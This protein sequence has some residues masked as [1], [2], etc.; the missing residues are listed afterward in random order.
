MDTTTSAAIDQ[1]VTSWR[2]SV[3][4]GLAITSVAIVLVGLATI[5]HPTKLSYGGNHYADWLVNYAGGF[6][7]R[8]LSGEII[9][10][11][12]GG[13]PAIVVTN[14][15]VFAI[16][17]AFALGLCGL[18]AAST[19]RWS[20]TAL[21]LLAPGSI[22]AMATGNDFYY[23]KEVL[24]H[25]CLVLSALLVVGI[26]KTSEPR[27]KAALLHGLTGFITVVFAVVP[28]MHE[29]FIFLS[30]PAHLLLLYFAG[31]HTGAK[32]GNIIAALAFVSIAI[33]CF[34][35]L[36]KG[37]TGTA[38]II[39]N[40][41]SSVDRHLI[42]PAAPGVPVGGI[43]AIGLSLTRAFQDVFAMLAT[44]YAWFWLPPFVFLSGCGLLISKLAI[45][46]RRGAANS[47]WWYLDLYLLV[48]LC[49][50]P[51]YLL[52]I[53]W[54]RWLSSNFICYVVVLVVCLQ[55]EAAQGHRFS[56]ASS[57]AYCR[58]ML[59]HLMVLWPRYAVATVLLMA[60]TVKMPECCILGYDQTPMTLLI[61][62]IKGGTG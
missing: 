9:Q 21:V 3:A 51:I 18:L 54:G 38:A 19:K 50:A 41:L 15:I 57:P 11:I 26:A 6:V 20:I 47:I 60:V 34:T 53:D 7:R 43:G 24:F 12:A 52:A 39:W 17:A 16:F 10:Q 40:S 55:L 29:G 42:N 36:F 23:R 46:E 22:F 32:T 48:F 28:F 14:V 49:S 25:L 35:A 13:N 59:D 58:R 2:L 44:G 33:F 4:V 27:A 37:S 62:F 30:A 56:G 8:G 31:R 5:W 1:P 45:E 61:R